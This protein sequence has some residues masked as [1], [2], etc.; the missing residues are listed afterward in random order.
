MR[1]IATFITAVIAD[2]VSHYVR[3]W[4]DRDKK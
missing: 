3:K 1:V 4:L 2:I